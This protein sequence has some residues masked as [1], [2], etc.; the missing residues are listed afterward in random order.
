MMRRHCQSALKISNGFVK[1]RSMSSVTFVGSY[2][3]PS[4]VLQYN[5]T[6]SV[7]SSAGVGEVKVTL[8]SSPVIVE[9]ILAVQGISFQNS[10]SDVAGVTGAGVVSEVGP[11]V[12]ESSVK[13]NVFVIGG[14]GTWTKDVIVSSRSIYKIPSLSSEQIAKLP[15][16]LSAFG[17][18][19]KFKDL[20]ANDVV[21]Q[22]NGD[23]DVGLAIS[24]LAKSRGVKVINV[25]VA[26][27]SDASSLTSKVGS[28]TIKYAVSGQGG[29]ALTSL[30]RH[31]S[32]RAYVVTYNSGFY[33]SEEFGGF[34][35]AVR[36]FIFQDITLSGF[37][38]TAWAQNDKL[39]VQAALNDVTE[40]ISSK[41]INVTGGKV[42]PIADF[43]KAVAF[44]QSTPGATA[45][46][47]I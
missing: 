10:N 14:R 40:L 34:D 19:S 20:K 8:K 42:F 1:V 38:L 39:A 30:V 9:D 17:I 21:I 5:P 43:A 33:L 24:E 32:P 31:S 12:V 47:D 3:Q 46:L 6:S 45:T 44:V 41:K 28:S 11:G 15:S 18:L 37:D 22:L 16:F 25:T 26:D 27:L 4:T 23:S 29:K 36:S 2:G 7:K 13:D 35:G